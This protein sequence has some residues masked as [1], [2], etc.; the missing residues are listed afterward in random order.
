MCTFGLASG[1]PRRCAEGISLAY[2]R[3]RST[4]MM[5]VPVLSPICGL[6]EDLEA[7][8]AASRASVTS[9]VGPRLLLVLGAAILAIQIQL[10]RYAGNML[11][12]TGRSLESTIRI[13]RSWTGLAWKNL[14]EPSCFSGSVPVTSKM[15]SLSTTPSP[16]HKHRLNTIEA[17]TTIRPIEGKSIKFSL[18]RFLAIRSA[19]P[20]STPR[21][22]NPTWLLVLPFHL[23]KVFSEALL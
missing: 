6:C 15:T 21:A 1:G 14:S 9:T 16:R 10:S 12:A 20:L 22:F 7:F 19:C 5:P 23:R 11:N 3:M 8:H 18:V 2:C 17:S 13:N 4:L